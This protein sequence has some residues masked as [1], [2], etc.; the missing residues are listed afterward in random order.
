MRCAA[1][2]VHYTPSE[3]HTVFESFT[4]SISA[5]GLTHSAG[6]ARILEERA[7]ISQIPVKIT[8]RSSLKFPHLHTFTDWHVNEHTC[9]AHGTYPTNAA[10]QPPPPP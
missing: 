5:E 1:N 10:L 3:T 7:R 8:A 6:S 9:S 2:A 4:R